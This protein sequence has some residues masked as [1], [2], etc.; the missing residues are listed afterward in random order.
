MSGPGRLSVALCTFNGSRYLQPQLLSI[1]GQSRLPDEL[2]ICD[3]CSTDR[4]VEIVREFAASAPFPVRLHV[5]EQNLGST[6]NFEKAIA[7]CD[8]DLISLSDQDD[9]WLPEKLRRSERAL[10]ADP[11]AGVAFSDAVVVNHRLEAVGYSLWTAAGFTRRQRDAF[12]GGDAMPLLLRKQVVTGA[13][14]VFRAELRELVLPIPETVVHDGWIA[15]LAAATSGLA[16]V[17]EPLLLYRQHEANQIGVR[18]EGWVRRARRDRASGPPRYLTMARDRYALALERLRERGTRNPF[19]ERALEAGARH[20]EA[21]SA[22]SGSL[23]RRAP[24]VL[25]ELASGR[26][27]R[28]SNG[29]YSLVEDLLRP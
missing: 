12:R 1:A 16:P 3:D 24:A 18:R 27:F 22:L 4:T 5:N 21:R 8:G 26:Y 10:L 6:R 2:V 14:M 25:R 17:D 13:A 7:L 11:G 15:L 9:V 19:A 23:P 20:L 29:L 28:Y